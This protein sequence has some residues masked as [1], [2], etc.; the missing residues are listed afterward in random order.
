MGTCACMSFLERVETNNFKSQD[1]IRLDDLLQK[2]SLTEY[3]KSPIQVFDKFEIK[4]IG[5]N[6]FNDLRNGIK[7]DLGKMTKNTFI[8]CNN[9][10]VGIIKPCD[11][12]EKLDTYLYE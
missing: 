3:L 11:K 9:E 1:A 5:I 7:V 10:L 12:A 4:E 2:S 6:D 8:V